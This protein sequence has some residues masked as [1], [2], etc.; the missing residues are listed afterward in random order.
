V[1]FNHFQDIQDDFTEFRSTLINSDDATDDRSVTFR[2][3]TQYPARLIALNPPPVS[4][5]LQTTQEEDVTVDGEI[6]DD[7][8]DSICGIE[9]PTTRSLTYT[10]NYNEFRSPQAITYENTFVV[11]EFSDGTVYG[12]QQLFEEKPGNDQINLLLLNESVSL[13]GQGT[14]SF[15]ISPSNQR[16]VEVRNPT[17]TI[18]SEFDESEWRNEILADVPDGKLDS[19]G[20]NAITGTG[21]GRFEITIRFDGD[22]NVSCQGTE[23]E[24]EGE[25]TGDGTESLFD[26]QWDESSP[27]T[28]QPDSNVDL[29]AEVLERGTNRRIDDAGVGFA[30]EEGIQAGTAELR[31]A[32]LR[33]NDGRATVTLNTKVGSGG[34]EFKIYVTAGDDSDVLTVEIEEEE[35]P[36][37]DDI[38]AVPDDRGGTTDD[39]RDVEFTFSIDGDTTDREVRVE[40]IAAGGERDEETVNADQ[41]SVSI[42]W[43]GGGR[44]NDVSVPIELT[45]ELIE[46]D[47]SII[48]SCTATIEENDG[49]LEFSDFDCS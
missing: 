24:Q 28:V 9:N 8:I 43:G 26:T 33:T 22:Y 30:I 21:D 27:V 11:R 20:G 49:N 34:S 2:L 48:Q 46:N 45:I 37:F 12:E 36:E 47:S 25:E 15:E 31:N 40:G 4:G 16:T 39:V 7:N 41:D 13:S 14:R 32:D 6:L 29:T 5:Q 35:S 17:I 19:D 3:G 1:E 10:P 23:V 38:T 18:P 44:P 42:D